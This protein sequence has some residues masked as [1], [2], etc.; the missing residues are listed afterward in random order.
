[1]AGEQ[2]GQL[3]ALRATYVTLYDTLKVDTLREERTKLEARM[4]EPGFW[5]DQET[6]QAVVVQLKAVKSETDAFSTV[7]EKLDDVEVLDELAES[8]AELAE[9]ARELACA[10]GLLGELRLRTY[11]TGEHDALSAFV[12]LQAGAGGIDACDWSEM[13]MRLVSRYAERRGFDVEI[14]DL[15]REPTAGIRSATVHVKGRGAFGWLKSERGTHRLVRISPFDAQNRRQTAF[16]SVDITPE[17]DDTIEIE[18]KDGDIKTDYY[19]AGGAGGQHVNKT[20][21]AVRMTHLPTGIVAQCQNERHQHA[22]RRMALQMLKNRIHQAEL[23][24]RA[25]E[26]SSTYA[27]KSNMG[28][29]ASDRIR[30]YTMQPFTL[31]KDTRT[32][33]EETHIQRVLDGEIHGFVESYLRWAAG[34]GKK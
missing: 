19:R 27:S 16:C 32:G 5:D 23:E 11:F 30:T 28:F 15:D 29:G 10:D 33:H 2:A 24:K 8:E 1:V 17:F 12:T 21:S 31:V 18:I 7:S 34:E 25:A 9:V 3:K 20:S 14:V 4:G 13:L 6:A 22:N 26:A